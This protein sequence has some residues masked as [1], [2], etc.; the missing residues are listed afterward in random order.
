M[1]AT[2]SFRIDRARGLIRIQMSGLFTMADIAGFLEAR[3]RA[4]AELGCRP[5]QHM[6]LNDL[7]S[8]KI[9]SQEV[10]TAFREMLADPAF[11]SR[12]LAFVAAQTLAR[13]QLMRAL[14]GRDARCFDSVGEAE[15]WLLAE[16]ADE[17]PQPRYAIR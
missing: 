2:Y 17:M 16:E 1:K 13:S 10:V 14:D 4:H 9:Q 11:R 5:N 15:A 7:S 6:T 8:M 3:Q 12:R